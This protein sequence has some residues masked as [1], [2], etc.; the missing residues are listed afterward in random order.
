MFNGT[1]PSLVVLLV[2]DF[3]SFRNRV[4]VKDISNNLVNKRNYLKIFYH[5]KGIDTINLPTILH[6][7]AVT[8]SIPKYLSTY[9]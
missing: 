8:A 2:R 3:V 5:N 7:K 4:H 6:S 9:F 1:I